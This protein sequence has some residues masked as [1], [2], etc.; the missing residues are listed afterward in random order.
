MVNGRKA[1]RPEQHRGIFEIYI[2]AAER[3][4]SCEREYS[5]GERRSSY[6]GVV[7]CVG[8]AAK[9]EAGDAKDAIVTLEENVRD[10]YTRTGL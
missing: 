8:C 10:L 6:A 3:C 4:P 1:H 9:Q 2:P 7:V 5:A